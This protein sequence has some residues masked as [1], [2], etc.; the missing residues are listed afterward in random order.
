MTEDQLLMELV[1]QGRNT[2]GS[3]ED[4]VSRLIDQYLGPKSLFFLK[5]K[6]TDNLN[7]MNRLV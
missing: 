3:R 2:S 5:E 1:Q 4:M 6:I 7:Y